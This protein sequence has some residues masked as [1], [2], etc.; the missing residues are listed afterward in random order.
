V[1]AEWDE[2]MYAISAW[3]MGRSGH[4]V[5]T[6]L[7]GTLDYYNTKPPLNVWLIA[8]SFKAFGM[9]IVSLRLVSVVSAWLTVAVLLGWARRAFGPAVAILAG[10]VLA[11]SF[12]FVYVHSG[13]TAETDALFALLILLTVVALWAEERQPWHRAWLGLIAAAVF[14]LRGMA[15]LMPLAIIAAVV[16][17]RKRGRPTR[18]L[19]TMAAV[20]LFL[21][22]VGV[23]VLARW[24]IDQ[25]M[26]FERM[27]NYDFVAR[28][29]T[30][31]EE[32]PGTP[33]YYLNILQKHQYDW[34]LAA[35]AA[36]VLFPVLWQQLRQRLTPFWNGDDATG[37]LVG[38]WA[39]VTFLMPT[40]MRTKL[41]WY[42]NPFYP[43]FAIAIAWILARALAQ[44]WSGSFGP[45]PA[46]LGAIVVLAFGV[47]EGKLLW[48]SFHY[49]D[50]GDS[51]QGLL[52]QEGH[53]LRNR[54][55]FQRNWN[56][57]DIF[58][59]SGIVGAQRRS[60]D[61]VDIFW[62][63]SAPGDCLLSTRHLTDPRLVLVRSGRRHHLYCRAD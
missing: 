57:A 58:V 53:R 24:R 48:Y 19:P 60:G 2:A 22:P 23:W 6:T 16:V 49:R 42:L 30:V 46:I 10:L 9:N 62:R 55:V 36:L 45:R 3:E 37:V 8:L 18:W 5:A 52:L 13:R 21:L 47:A 34:L 31:I 38:S 50:L 1:V 33:L 4:V 11:T 17:G 44:D 29:L 40:M 26:F 15:V 28:S 54:H 63:D 27:F 7:L 59:A 25:W 35:A 14:L 20:A 56:R 43:V 32:H 41:P 12:G 61:R 51:A 39:A